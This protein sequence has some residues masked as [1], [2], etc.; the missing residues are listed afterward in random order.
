MHFSNCTD[1]NLIK[2]KLFLYFGR[3]KKLRNSFFPS[4]SETENLAGS[5]K[6]IFW[7]ASKGDK[8][9]LKEK[10]NV[11]SFYRLNRIFIF[12]YTFL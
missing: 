10:K 2:Q 1:L 9:E 11:I 7:M 6:K 4:H 3:F 8:L 12:V 5:D